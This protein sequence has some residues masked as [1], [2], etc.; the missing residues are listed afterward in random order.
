MGNSHYVL[1]PWPLQEITGIYY[2]S[3]QVKNLIKYWWKTWADWDIT[4]YN[5]HNSK[6]YFYQYYLHGCTSEQ[7]L[8]SHLERFKLLGGQRLKLPEADNKKG[9]DKIKIKKT[10]YQLC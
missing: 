10:E 1:P 4:K 6:Q 3:L 2:I 8:K 7:V 5:N 9:R